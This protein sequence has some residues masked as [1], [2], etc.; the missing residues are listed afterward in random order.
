MNVSS[1]PTPPTMLMFTVLPSPSP[2]VS[3]SVV[4]L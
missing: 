1:A 3:T 2:M 4:A